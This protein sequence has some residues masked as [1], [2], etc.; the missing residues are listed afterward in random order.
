MLEEELALQEVGAFQVEESL[1]CALEEGHDGLHHIFLQGL[2]AEDGKPARNLWLRWPEAAEFGPLRETLVL[3][4]CPEK[5]LAGTLDQEGCCLPDH[6][7]GRHG[8][9]F[10]PPI[11]EADITPDWLL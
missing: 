9:E 3:P 8:F 5:F 4:P 6:H 7:P 2:K 10:G 11:S 1:W